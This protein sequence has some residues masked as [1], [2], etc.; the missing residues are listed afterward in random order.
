V[1]LRRIGAIDGVPT[2]VGVYGAI[3]GL[4]GLDLKIHVNY[5]VSAMV[6]NALPGRLD[7]VSPADFVRDAAG[8]IMGCK[9]LEINQVA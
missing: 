4:P 8:K 2:V 6:R 5:I 3:E 9:A 7:L 1:T